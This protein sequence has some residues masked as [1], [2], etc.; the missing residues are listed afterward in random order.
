MREIQFEEMKKIEL[1]ILIYFTEVCEENN[2]RYYLGGGTLLGAVRHKG[3][4]PW[5]DDIDVMM[6]RPDFQK[7]LS[8]SINNE[9]YNIIKPGAEGYY[10]NFA[11][12]VDTRTILEEKGIKRIDGLGVYIDIFPLDGMPE[13]P[14]ARKKRFKEL[15]SIRK[16]INN[17]CLLKP[18]FHRNPFAYLNA[19]RIY[20]SNKNIDLSSLQKKY[21]DSALKNSFDDSEFVFAAGGAYGARDIFPGKWFEKEIELQFENLSVKAFNGYDF[22]L[23][24]LYGDYMTLPPEDKRVTPHHTI[25]YFK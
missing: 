16:R 11:K 23:T 8:L 7:L 24:Q 25:V 20:N 12:L 13:T 15:N 2:L 3:F 21:L 14:D 9:N 4:I 19:C 17:T 5:D 18:K 6:P 10:Y 1:N 22:Y